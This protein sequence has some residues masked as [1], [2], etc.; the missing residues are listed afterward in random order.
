M[1][2]DVLIV[3]GVNHFAGVSKMVFVAA[4][5]RERTP[6]GWGQFVTSLAVINHFR[7]GTKMVGSALRRMTACMGEK[8]DA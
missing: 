5:H 3:R 6:D 2:G 8:A 7:E 4:M 1:R